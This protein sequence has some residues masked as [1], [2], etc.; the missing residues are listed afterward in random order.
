[1]REVDIAAAT[2]L[3]DV[4][5]IR[6][7]MRD[8]WSID[9]AC[10][11]DRYRV[12]YA[13]PGLGPSQ[14]FDAIGYLDGV[15]SLP[16]DGIVATH[17]NAALLA[18]LAAQRRGLPGPKPEAV[19]ACQYKPASRARQRVAVPHAVPR[20]A[21]LDPSAAFEPPFFV[22][23]AIGTLSGGARRIDDL[24]QLGIA[25]GNG[26]ASSYAPVAQ[27]MGLSVVDACGYLMEELMSGDEAMLEG[28]VRH[29]RLTTIGI[30]DSAKY[31]GTD[32]FER[33][34]YPTRL[35]AERQAE[36]IDTAERIVA[37]L[38]FDDSLLNIEFFVP[39]R[40]PVKIIEVNP[41]IAAQY[42]PLIKALHGRST[43]EV[44]FALACGEDPRWQ[45]QLP[46]GAAT[47][48]CLRA[49]DDA[50]VERVPEPQHGLEILVEPGL[51]LSE[52]QGQNDPRSYR[53]AL[54]Y[55]TGET[56]EEALLRCRQRA[57]TLQFGLT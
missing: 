51:R 23:P 9:H 42:A 2:A 12:H 57:R 43:Y 39:E 37:E 31:A 56:R 26:H 19:F 24:R 14:P 1:M 10:L 25:D 55:E 46:D 33:F 52:Q 36:L 8:L 50:F 40:G 7:Q 18:A 41:R 29:G 21:I 28:Y 54:F 3:K 4:L 45:P 27:L 44:L 38:G 48:Y 53:L 17:D 6:P 15:A 49:F 30:T 11:G 47:S 5:V 32:S 34:E 35:S 13:Y 20:Y 16:A 22:K